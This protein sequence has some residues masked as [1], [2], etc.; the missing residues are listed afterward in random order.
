MESGRPIGL[1][2]LSPLFEHRP[3]PFTGQ[4]RD[5]LEGFVVPALPKVSPHLRDDGGNRQARQLAVHVALQRQCEPSP[6]IHDFTASPAPR[7]LPTVHYEAPQRHVDTRHKGASLP[8][9]GPRNG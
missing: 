2:R 5:Q 7:H 1:S 3:E 4:S 6:F 9:K 8:D